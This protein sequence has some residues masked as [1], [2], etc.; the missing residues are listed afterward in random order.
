MTKTTPTTSRNVLRWTF[1]RGSNFIAC[2]LVRLNNRQY[3]LALVPLFDRGQGASETFES[4]L[5]AFH[6]HA[7]IAS[8]LRESGWKVVAY[9]GP[10]PFTPDYAP[11]MERPAA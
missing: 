7:T 6:R 11:S 10:A 1:R 5:A 8:T 4:G 9:S 3:S 2:E